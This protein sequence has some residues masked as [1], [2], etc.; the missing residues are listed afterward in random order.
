MERFSLLVPKL[1]VESLALRVLEELGASNINVFR[2]GALDVLQK[3]RQVWGGFILTCGLP[4]KCIRVVKMFPANEIN[5][6][7]S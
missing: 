6:A 1:D 7:K 2:N 3:I 5:M 4:S